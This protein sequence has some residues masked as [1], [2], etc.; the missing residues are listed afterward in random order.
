ML[1]PVEL[2]ALGLAAARGTQLI[3]HD[4]ILDKPRNRL[5]IWHA[6]RHDSRTRTFVRDGLSCVLCA[7]FWASAITVAAHHTAT[8][9]HGVTPL[10]FGIDAFTVAAVQVT[11]N[12]WW[13][14]P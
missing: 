5:E 12:L 7:G 1:G 9:W 13:D 10:N 11:I 6:K 2:A 4:S 3:V 8:T 14:R